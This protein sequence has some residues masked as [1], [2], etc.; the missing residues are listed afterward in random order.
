MHMSVGMA[1]LALSMSCVAWRLLHEYPVLPRNMQAA[2]RALAKIVHA[3]LYA[4]IVAVPV[5]G[6]AILSVRRAHAAMFGGFK[7][8][9]IPYLADMTYDQRVRIGDL[10]TPIHAKLSYI[11]MSLVLL[12]VLAAVF[13]HFWQR[14]EVLMR[15]LPRM[16]RR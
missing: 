12:H 16:R 9:V 6:W 10:L 5:T 11:G 13:H 1:V 2:A 7:W 4:F 14:D 8:P 15:M 3:L